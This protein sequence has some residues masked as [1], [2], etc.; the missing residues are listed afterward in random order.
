[1]AQLADAVEECGSLHELAEQ[2]VLDRARA[3][4]SSL[5]ETF[6]RVPALVTVTRLNLALHRKLNTVLSADFNALLKGLAGLEERGE[7]YVQMAE[8][9]ERESIARLREAWSQW[10][11]PSDVECSSGEILTPLPL[12]R[13]AVDASLLPPMERRITQVASG[14]LDD[15]QAACQ[16]C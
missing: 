10:Q 12:V 7:S 16:V 11:I 5:G 2:E 14:I 15:Q 3:L 6:Y 8:S 1:M 9:G 13:D 4:K